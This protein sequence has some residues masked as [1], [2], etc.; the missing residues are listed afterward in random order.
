MSEGRGDV[1]SSHNTCWV[2]K[3][4]RAGTVPWN[5]A[6]TVQPTITRTSLPCRIMPEPVNEQKVNLLWMALEAVTK[7]Y[8][9]MVDTIHSCIPEWV[10]TV[11]QSIVTSPQH[12][13]AA[14][15]V[16]VDHIVV[17]SY[18]I[19]SVMEPGSSVREDGVVL[20][21]YARKLGS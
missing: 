9:G 1:T 11:R 17:P 14:C 19:C 15:C 21:M 12:D 13:I 7:V 2:K 16:T 20:D 10:R 18:I 5:P 6:E 8:V 3:A 4:K